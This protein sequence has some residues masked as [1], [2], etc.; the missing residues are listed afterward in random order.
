MLCP[1]VTRAP[2]IGAAGHSAAAAQRQGFEL[3]EIDF[4]A[5]PTD[6]VSK[7]N[8]VQPSRSLSHLSQGPSCALPDESHVA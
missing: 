2:T 6:V 7:A 5:S 8:L 3:D 4:D 1:E